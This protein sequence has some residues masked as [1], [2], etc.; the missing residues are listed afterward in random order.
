MST[1]ALGR[2]IIRAHAEVMRRMD[3]YPRPSRGEDVLGIQGRT[4]SEIRKGLPKLSKRWMFAVRAEEI[5]DP[6]IR[7]FGHLAILFGLWLQREG[8][9]KRSKD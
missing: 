2:T 1:Y 5:T 3:K 4:Q 9:E 8:H 6:G 7:R